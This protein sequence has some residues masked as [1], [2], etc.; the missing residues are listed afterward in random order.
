[1]GRSNPPSGCEIR[2]LSSWADQLKTRL[3]SKRHLFNCNR[4]GKVTFQIQ[5]KLWD[6]VPFFFCLNN[7]IKSNLNEVLTTKLFCILIL[8]LLRYKLVRLRLGGSLIRYLILQT[9]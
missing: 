5:I 6:A 9:I 1:M 4:H 2:P 8:S 7:C 3:P